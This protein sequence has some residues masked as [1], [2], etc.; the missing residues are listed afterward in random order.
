MGILNIFKFRK[1]LYL[2]QLDQIHSLEELFHESSFKASQFIDDLILLKEDLSILK[3]MTLDLN[4]KIILSI[5]KNNIPLAKKALN[6]KLDID[7]DI[8]YLEKKIH[9][10]NKVENSVENLFENLKFE[11]NKILC[12]YESKKDLALFSKFNRSLKDSINK[13]KSIEKTLSHS[14]DSIYKNLDNIKINNSFNKNFEEEFK[15]YLLKDK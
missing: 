5:N 8:F 2:K 13:F 10:L 7:M 3:E 9:Y 4:N 15:K 14:L 11:Y 6:K 1:D 12:N